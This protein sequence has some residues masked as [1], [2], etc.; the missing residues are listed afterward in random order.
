MFRLAARNLPTAATMM[1]DLIDAD[2]RRRP[3]NRTG[4]SLIIT[5]FKPR[6]QISNDF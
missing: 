3:A 2:L 4:G 6:F 5:G 1:A